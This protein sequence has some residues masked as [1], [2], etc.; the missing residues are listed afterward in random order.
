MTIIVSCP[1]SLSLPLSPFLCIDSQ[2]SSRVRNHCS[3]YVSNNNTNKG[4]RRHQQDKTSE[5][6]AG[7]CSFAEPTEEGQTTTAGDSLDCWIFH[8][9]FI[10]Q[11]VYN[12]CLYVHCYLQMKF[13]R[14]QCQHKG[15]KG[16]ET[17]SP[18]T[19]RQNIYIVKETSGG[20]FCITGRRAISIYI[21]WHEIDKYSRLL[22]PR[23]AVKDLP[24]D[25]D[26]DHHHDFSRRVLRRSRTRETASQQ[27]EELNFPLDICS[28]CSSR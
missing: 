21:I 14:R 5:V 2:C 11:V 23:G 27:A 18:A 3:H 13:A 8:A 1:F 6:T 7:P 17:K 15:K 25:K 28:S 20:G 16:R 10:S 26:D 24:V 19:N 9:Q 22:L 12:L 4:G